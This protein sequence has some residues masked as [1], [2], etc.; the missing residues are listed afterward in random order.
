MLRFEIETIF[1]TF[2][3]TKYDP[4]NLQNKKHEKQRTKM[5]LQIASA[6]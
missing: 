5:H 1:V 6:L 2:N 3:G 4:K